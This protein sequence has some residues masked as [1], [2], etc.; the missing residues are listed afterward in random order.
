MYGW[1]HDESRIYLILEFA[2]KGNLYE[3]L[4]ERE[5]LTNEEAAKVC[6]HQYTCL[7]IF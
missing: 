6:A 5:K 4:M 7:I 1:F 2:P 3:M